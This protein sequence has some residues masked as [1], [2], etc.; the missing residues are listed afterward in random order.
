[1]SGDD[2]LSAAVVAALCR[3]RE[4]ERMCREE[5]KPQL[6]SKD[7]GSDPFEGNWIILEMCPLW[8]AAV[9]HSGSVVLV[10]Y[11]SLV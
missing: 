10:M 1:M 6:L 2:S 3:Q 7:C 11:V 8:S 4:A 9:L 5:E